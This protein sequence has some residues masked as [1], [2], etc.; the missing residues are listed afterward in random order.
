MIVIVYL[1]YTG[2]NRDLDNVRATEINDD[3]VNG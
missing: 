1:S 3:I 2:G